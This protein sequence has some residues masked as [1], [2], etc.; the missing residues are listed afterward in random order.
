MH[1]I[2]KFNFHKSEIMHSSLIGLALGPRTSR[3]GQHEIPSLFHQSAAASLTTGC[4]IPYLK[5]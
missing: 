4:S 5:M 1:A 2:I 3:V